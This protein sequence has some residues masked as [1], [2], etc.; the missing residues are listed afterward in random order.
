MSD[1]IKSTDVFEPKIFANVTEEIKAFNEATAKA[2]THLKDLKE[3]QISLSKT[4]FDNSKSIKDYNDQVQKSI[5][6]EQK[7]AKEAANA[8][9][10]V[11][12][13]AIKEEKL[14]QEQIKT[15][16]TLLKQAD[17]ADKAA[18]K[19]ID[20]TQ[21][22]TKRVR[23]LTK[24]LATVDPVK[25]AAR[26]QAIA[27]EAGE[28]KDKIQD[29]RE[30]IK[31]F[32]KDSKAS[33]AKTLFGQIAGDIGNL[34][35]SA[36]ADK[37]RQFSALIKTIT[38]TEVISG[39]KSLGSALLDVGRSLL[40][41]PFTI[42]IG[43]IAAVAYEI[44]GLFDSIDAGDASLKTLDENL[45]KLAQST[46]ELKKK[47]RDLRIEND[48]LAGKYDK[49][50]GEKLKAEV[51]F[52]DTVKE[53]L[54]AQRQ[55]VKKFNEDIAKEREED[56]FKASKRLYEFLG[57]ETELTKKQKA[58]LLKIEQ[59]YNKK[60]MQL[61]LLFREELN[62]VNLKTE[63][64]GKDK[65]VKVTKEI[66]KEQKFDWEEYYD[67]LD[68]LSANN[69]ENEK[70]RD[71]ELENI[72]YERAVRAAKEKY[73]TEKELKAILE[74]LE[75]EHN[76]KLDAINNKT[77]EVKKAK[78]AA[79]DSGVAEKAARDK[80]LEEKKKALEDELNIL[81]DY[82]D[83]A[84]KL[85][86]ERQEKQLNNELDMRQ[87]NI[88]Q[89]QQLAANGLNNTLAF[90]KAAADKAEKE[91]QILAEKNERM[92]KRIAFL[93]LFASFAEKDPD[94]ALTKALVQS[95]IANAI[96][97]SYFEGTENVGEDLKGNKIHNGRD[98]YVVAVDGSERIVPGDDNK[99]MGNLTNK[100]LAAIASDYNTGRLIPKYL[101]E[102]IGGSF[103]ENA[104]NSMLL[105]Q[106]VGMKSEIS[107][108]KKALIERPSNQVELNNLGEVINR[109]IQ[110][111]FTV[112]RKVKPG[113]SPLNYI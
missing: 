8:A 27:K 13:A 80:A 6:L 34:D 82:L 90:E 15:N 61:R 102:P 64:K 78:A 12:D 38:F 50:T 68:T 62:N 18:K 88:M 98:G 77:D 87:R 33:Q 54:E 96:A 97:G 10:A 14:K 37:A 24:E 86:S 63:E 93:K 73:K 32:T 70:D 91:K 83:K 3:V 67:Y 51:R 35:F 20:N 85:R 107:G 106:V 30:A 109:K 108:I 103:A 9:K 56:G 25:D 41:N 28:L 94:Q 19:A 23:E 71:T 42:L 112:E 26:Y 99:K 47:V 58:G 55:E 2:A 89:Q 100:E 59:D 92:Q 60:I 53:L 113:N 44:K 104:V 72:R 4:T 40:N 22:Y 101:S 16:E 111:G 45:A 46:E 39:L 57:G 75:I 36:A 29:A 65:S 79:D 52:T 11:T 66:I 43:V 21:N 7:V 95:A 105:Q 69:M 17:A 5:L 31:V 81:I 1:Q 76:K 110:R 49:N 84:D 74:Q 48:I